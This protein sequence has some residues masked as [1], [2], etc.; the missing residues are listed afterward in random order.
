MKKVAS[1]G[2]LMIILGVVFLYR[3]DI[4]T[5]YV[6]TFVKVNEAKPITDDDRNSYSTK[7]SYLYVQ[8]T[9]DFVPDNKQELMNIYYTLLDSGMIDYSF[10]CPDS[11]SSCIDDV[12][13]ISNDQNILS[14][15]NNFVHPFNSFKNIETE[16][17]TLGKITIHILHTYS[18]DTIIEINSKVDSI[19]NEIISD[20]SNVNNNIKLIHDYI[21]NNTKYDKNRTDNNITTYSSDTA[22]GPLLQG[23]GICGGYTDAMGIFLS[24]LGLENI[25]IASENHVWNLVK[26]DDKWLHLDL[27]WDDPI[28]VNG[29]ETIEYTFYLIDYLTLISVRT[30]QHYFDTTIYQEAI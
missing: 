19:I 7:K 30:D 10:Y 23:Y 9:D 26:L 22:Y 28:N 5:F 2:I 4:V 11:Y 25:R 29:S 15:I 20:E 13:D 24:K 14:N 6:N 8:Q 17:D 12:K 18:D 1:T 3:T 21:I 16:Y 27:T